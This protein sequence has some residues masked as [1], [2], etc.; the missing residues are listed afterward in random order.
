MNADIFNMHLG[1]KMDRQCTICKHYGIHSEDDQELDKS[2]I[3]DENGTAVTLL[4]CRK[5]AVELFK[6]GQRK[7]LVNH[8][9]I[10]IDLVS[11]DEA[12][13]IELLQKTVT[14]NL[15]EIY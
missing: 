8:H 2:Q 1:G 7:F 11:S 6:E 12:K 14:K 5:H 15:D 3:F 9:K 10:L 13:F 4:L